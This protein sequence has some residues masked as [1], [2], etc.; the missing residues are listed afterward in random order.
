MYRPDTTALVKTSRYL[1]TC[2]LRNLFSTEVGGG[3]AVDGAGVGVSKGTV[4][5]QRMSSYIYFQQ[6]HRRKAKH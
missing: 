3:K 1:L 4:P 2:V 5:T 6:L